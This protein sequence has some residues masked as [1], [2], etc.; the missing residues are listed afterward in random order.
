[1]AAFGAD[2]ARYVTL[3]EVAF[4]RDT[5]VSWDSFVRRYNADLANDYG[6]LDN[7]TVSMVNRYLTGQRPAARPAGEALLAGAWRT[8]LA[9][10]SAKLD[11]YL[12]HD[13]LSALWD[14]VGAANKAVDTAAP[15]TLAKAAKAGDADAAVRLRDVLGDLVEA[16]RLVGLAAAPFMPGMAP[17]VLAQ[18][19][20]AY[21]Y[22]ADGNG[23]PALPD[24]L[25]WG[26][27]TAAGRVTDTPVPL[28]P[29]MESE[30]APEARVSPGG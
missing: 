1:V 29:R 7:R 13:A 17:K 5:E 23:G 24:L 19:G 20:Y 15:W 16:C 18:L 30:A 12:L 10:Y 26:A 4:D 8:A 6:N 21:P 22:G 14:F 28:F 2:G 3:A 11:G 9:G 25:A 27:A